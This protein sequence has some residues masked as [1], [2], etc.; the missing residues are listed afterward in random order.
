MR[1]GF[2]N[3]DILLRLLLLDLAINIIGWTVSV[4]LKTHKNYDLFG[5]VSFCIC[6]AVSFYFST[7]RSTIQR[8]QSLCIMIWAL[9]LGGYLTLR[10][11]RR[12]DARLAKY[13]DQPLKFIFPFFLQVV[14]VYLMSLPSYVLN[15]REEVPEVPTALSYVGWSLWLIGFIFEVISDFQ[16]DQFLKDETNQGKFIKSG[17]WSISRHPNYVGEILLWFGLFVSACSG[18]DWWPQYLSGI[19]VIFIYLLLRYVSG[20]KMLEDKGEKKWGHTTE[21]KKYCS[22]VPVLLPFVPIYK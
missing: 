9:R 11:I 21:Y 13:D 8:V 5:S 16:K 2:L 14:W 1:D 12:G 22:T 18:F 6:T 17:L 15:A 19:S 7:C 4:T 20:V 10:G 3:M